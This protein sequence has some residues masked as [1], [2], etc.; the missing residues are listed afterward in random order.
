MSAR[1]GPT[2]RCRRRIGAGTVAQGSTIVHLILSGLIRATFCN[3]GRQI[4]IND[5]LMRTGRGGLRRGAGRRPASRPPIHHV[6][7]ARF[8]RLTPGLV[9]IRVRKDVPSLRSGRFMRAFRESLAACSERGRFRVLHYSVQS[10]HIHLIVENTPR[11]GRT[12]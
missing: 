9:T 5:I 1:V 3:V 6:K 10:D 12:L 2:T 7:R 11:M 4:D 8:D